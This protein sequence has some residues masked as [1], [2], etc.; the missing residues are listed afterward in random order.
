M[1]F[2]C[3]GWKDRQINRWSSNT[4]EL[5][6]VRYCRR[7]GLP[8]AATGTQAEH[9]SRS[10]LVSLA[11]ELWG[12]KSCSGVCSGQRGPVSLAQSLGLRGG[13][14]SWPA[15]CGSAPLPSTARGGLPVPHVARSVSLY[16]SPMCSIGMLHFLHLPQ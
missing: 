15:P 4:F 1:S 14:R 16:R 6:T 8:P 3:C 10:S 9:R 11:S 12:P 13:A 2:S 7:A 5:R